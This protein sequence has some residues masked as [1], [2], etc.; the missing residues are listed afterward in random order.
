MRR[1]ALYVL[2]AAAVALTALLAVLCFGG[3]F[4][5]QE[6]PF[7]GFLL[8]TNA[9]VTS[10]MRSHWEG[11]RLGL[12]PRDVVRAVDGTEIHSAAQVTALLAYHARS[13]PTASAD[14]LIERPG[15]PGPAHVR[16]QLTHLST[17][18]VA[19]VFVMP[20]AIGVLYLVLG[21]VV[22]FIKRTRAAAI[23]LALSVC[24]AAFYLTMFDAHMTYKWSRIWVCYP[25]LG[26]ISIHL[27]AV[28]P[29]ERPRVHRALVLGPVY[30]AAGLL[31]LLR[32]IY[33]ADPMRF[34]FT[35]FASNVQLA[36]CFA[37][38]L[39]LLGV[40]WART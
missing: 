10:L 29:E 21:A 36:A 22:F 2:P 40:T 24:A 33:L 1:S 14:F 39:A 27:F 16:V 6:R 18:D 35:S 20:F 8:Y 23:V 37:T 26:A 25:L 19:Y 31:V 15:A 28:F 38:D 32:Q 3:A 4:G 13:A 30:A 11:P 34:D 5:A 9:A 7:P 17:G 12:R